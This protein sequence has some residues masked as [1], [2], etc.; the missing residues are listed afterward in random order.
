MDP[1]S[2]LETTVEAVVADLADGSIQL[3]DVREPD[4]W[5]E[6]RIAGSMLIPMSELG[7]RVLDI[8]PARPVVTV[9]RVGARSYYVAE[10]LL[11]AGFPNVK[12]MAGG[13]NAWV[14]SG[15]PLEV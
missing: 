5:L 12:S 9:C 3:I 10:A 11:E 8:D 14:I 6:G 7:E 15:Q 1:Q 4:E 13:I 2:D